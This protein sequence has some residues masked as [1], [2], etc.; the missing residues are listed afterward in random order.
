MEVG[1]V[2]DVDEIPRA[3]VAF[4]DTG[5]GGVEQ[6]LRLAVDKEQDGTGHVLANPGHC[7]QFFTR[8]R[9]VNLAQPR[10]ILPKDDGANPNTACKMKVVRLKPL[11]I[12]FPCHL[13]CSCLQGPILE[14]PG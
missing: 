9:L 12:I 3:E 5:H 7:F 2:A 10:I 13:A 8:T 4:E 6:G 14:S 1:I 11:D